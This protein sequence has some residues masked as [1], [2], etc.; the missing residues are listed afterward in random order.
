MNAADYGSAIF[1]INRA[2]TAIALENQRDKML[3][4]TQSLNLQ[5]N[6]FHILCNLNIILNSLSTITTSSDY[7]THRDIFLE[8]RFAF[9]VQLSINMIATRCKM[10]FK[11]FVTFEFS[12]LMTGKN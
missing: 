6:T 3:D 11:W 1:N 10:K 8:G 2:L 12:G 4:I 5:K 7:Q 9:Q